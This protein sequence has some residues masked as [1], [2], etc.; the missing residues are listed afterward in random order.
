MA[1]RGKYTVDS[2]ILK[3]IDGVDY[4]TCLI[5]EDRELL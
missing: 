4:A 1:S 2:H 5:A 3:E